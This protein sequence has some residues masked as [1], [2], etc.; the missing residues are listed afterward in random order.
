M[1][2]AVVVPGVQQSESVITHTRFH[3]FRFFSYRGQAVT[4]D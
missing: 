1:H 4:E 2:I 3:S